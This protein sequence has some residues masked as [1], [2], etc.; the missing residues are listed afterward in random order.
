[1]EV[2]K[3]N[4]LSS[5]L[6]Q[7]ERRTQILQLIATGLTSSTIDDYFAN[8]LQ[9]SN[10]KGV[11]MPPT[12][13]LD[14]AILN[15]D[16]YALQVGFNSA[17]AGGT[18]TVIQDIEIADM[19]G[20]GK[21]D[22]V[23][24]TINVIM[25]NG[26]AQ[27]I[28][29]SSLD[30]MNCTAVKWRNYFTMNIV[31]PVELP[32]NT[33]CIIPMSGIKTL[34]KNN[35]L[36]SQ[37]EILTHSNRIITCGVLREVHPVLYDFAKSTPALAENVVYTEVAKNFAMGYGAIAASKVVI[38][39]GDDKFLLSPNAGGCSISVCKK[40]LTVIANQ[41]QQALDVT[42]QQNN[43]DE[44][45][46]ASAVAIVGNIASKQGIGTEKTQFIVNNVVATLPSVRV[47]KQLGLKN[48]NFPKD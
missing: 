27:Q 46:F 32:K 10:N 38:W 43:V 47:S 12:S 41:V 29:L 19:G 1:M 8:T 25:N 22:G 7:V 20:I 4:A 45:E 24:D 28:T 15:G 5:T 42:G 2:G 23:G 40:E 11:I 37:S 48:L 26:L 34:Q 13:L 36:M 16:E 44:N 17:A 3:F 33:L 21:T 30:P 35:D 18:F 6:V 9:V 31:S 14:L 39:T